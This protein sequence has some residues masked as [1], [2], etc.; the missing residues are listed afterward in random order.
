MTIEADELVARLQAALGTHY[1]IERELGRGGMGMVF[2]ATDTT[3]DR[4]VAVKVMHPD[5]SVHGSIIQRFLAEA[6]MIAKLRHPNIVAVH[7]AGEATGIFYY[8]MDHV[9]GDSLRERLNRVGKLGPD[10]AG[11]IMADMAEALAAAG[12]AGLVHR[13]IKPEN[14]LLDEAT[15]RALL[16]DFGIARVAAAETSLQLT[17]Q[18]IAVGTPTYMSP[19]QAAGE[20]VDT[21]SDLYGLGIVG[22]E[23]LAGHPPFR[24]AN[25]AAVISMQLS[26]KPVPIDRIRPE[27]PAALVIAVMRALEKSPDRRWQTGTEMSRALRGDPG[28]RLHSRRK[29]MP[30]LIGAGA[31]VLTLAGVALALTSGNGPPDGINPRHSILILPFD[32][33]REDQAVDWLREGSVNMLSLNM[34]Q[35]DDLSVVDHERLH[36]LLGHHKLAVDAPIGLEMARQLARDA[37][38]WTVVLGDY[39]RSG[40]SLHLSA[41]V[42]DVASGE[43]IDVAQVNGVSGEDPR[44][45][46][47]E[48]A[49][50]LLDLSGAPGAARA[51]LSALTTRSLEAYRAYLRGID[52]LNQW[53]LT[54]AEQEFRHAL[55]EDSTFGLAYYK[56]ALTRGWLVGAND[57]LSFQAIG[58]ATRFSGG[59]P[60]HERTVINAYRAF[61]N[62]DYVTSQS[63]YRSLLARDSNDADA[64]YGLG[65]ALFHDTSSVNVAANKTTSLR[66]FNRTLALD[67]AYTLAYEHIM[68]MLTE[69]SNERPFL[70]LVSRDSFRLATSKTGQPILDSAR[71]RQAVALARSEA[72]A[73]GHQW[74]TNQPDAIRAHT[75]LIEVMIASRDF[76]GA[77]AE[78]QRTRTMPAGVNRPDLVFTEGRIRF[79]SGDIDGAVDAF[80]HAMDTL[81]AGDFSLAPALSYV[82]VNTAAGVFSYIGDLDGATRA[83]ELGDSVRRLIRPGMIDER[84]YEHFQRVALGMLY[85]GSG[86][87]VPELRRLWESAAEEARTAPQ[88]RRPDLARSGTPAAVGLFGEGDTTALTEL[89]ALTREPLPKEF[90]ALIAVKRGES[91]E[92]RRILGEQDSPEMRAGWSGDISDRRPYEAQAWYLLG[93]YQRAIDILD[94]FDPEHLYKR[95]FDYRWSMVGR[96]R[97]LRA[98]ALEKLGRREAAATEYRAVLAQW[99][100]STSPVLEPYLRQAQQGLAR[101]TGEG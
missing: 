29:L 67:P 35:W 76:N 2:L 83:I 87:P 58:A 72:L 18:G 80:R 77:L 98:A 65:D 40:D 41:R 23:M 27:T 14:I 69:A 68:N 50:R 46:Y 73:A 95:G 88:S 13:D 47:D 11:R 100:E 94:G 99:K 59:L 64:W 15:G 79:A 24:G 70:A 49:A 4:P 93:D 52:L 75:N 1:R 90:R 89:K 8:V 54:S 21:R 3:L 84:S 96:V 5:L 28:R 91:A 66:S 78:L 19:E 6:R 34:S 25:G 45:L 51:N 101:T 33:L 32:N 22:Y 63:L 16:A 57:S 56:L 48:L 86:G 61:L 42:Y 92:A 9:P 20:T 37:G 55:D 30:M 31:L 53:E 85:A 60:Q 74:V 39:T 7:A 36:D 97:L 82:E 81:E 12:R 44:P 71:V 17:G 10:E 62:G 38:V 43:R 26:E